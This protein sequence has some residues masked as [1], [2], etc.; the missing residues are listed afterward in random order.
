MSTTQFC[1]PFLAAMLI[2]V[3]GQFAIAQ[4]EKTSEK[5]VTETPATETPVTE[6]QQ[7]DKQQTEQA[8]ETVVR[9][10]PHLNA[11]TARD[12]RTALPAMIPVDA[13]KTASW[14]FAEQGESANASATLMVRH[15]P[16]V[17]TQVKELLAIFQELELVSTG[18]FSLDVARVDQAKKASEEVLEWPAGEGEVWRFYVVPTP[19][20]KSIHIALK[21][22]IDGEWGKQSIWTVQ[23]P[24]TLEIHSDTVVVIRQTEEMHEKLGAFFKQLNEARN[25][26]PQVVSGGGFF[27]VPEDDQP[28]EHASAKEGE[29]PQSEQAE[30]MVV[31]FYPGLPKQTAD[32]I[33]K[34]IDSLVRADWLSN[35][36]ESVVVL[37]GSFVT[38]ATLV[39]RHQPAIQKHV[40]HLIDQTRL[41]HKAAKRRAAVDETLPENIAKAELP[42]QWEDTQGRVWQ[43]FWVP[44]GSADQL[45]YALPKLLPDHAN[46]LTVSLPMPNLE[47][48]LMVNVPNESRPAIEKFFAEWDQAQKNWVAEESGLGLKNSGTATGAVAVQESPEGHGFGDASVR[49]AAKSD[50]PAAE[51]N[52][53]T[54]YYNFHGRTAQSIQ[55]LLPQVLPEIWPAD[56]KT[57]V[58]FVPGM[59]DTGATI[60][61]L[62]VRQTPAGHEKVEAYFKTLRTASQE[63][64]KQID[65]KENYPCYSQPADDSGYVVKYHY[66]PTPMANHLAELLPK[67][68]VS[69]WQQGTVRTLSG[70]ASQNLQH[71]SYSILI[72]RQQP[73][74]HEQIDKVIRNVRFYDGQEAEVAVPVPAS[75][76]GLEATV[77]GGSF[78]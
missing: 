14:V 16:E 20:A 7:S 30:K 46:G 43:L 17:H 55:K 5:P 32:A 74:V 38:P 78:F 35:N 72:V 70:P 37:G 58:S 25:E 52:Y 73:A 39:V 77:G 51:A 9:F 3:S 33:V 8:N 67:Y 76:R 1:R 65:D 71:F 34:Q 62:M 29:K 48:V 12:L 40:S 61:I 75:L 4:P 2:L 31:R 21:Q 50:S 28:S 36:G 26:A 15:T 44:A 66:L 13:E 59:G 11:R 49:N 42:K 54:R 27:N 23:L 19:S 60:G 57:S 24:G 63:L 64:Q 47:S 10:Y 41:W 18:L 53:E 68:F 45:S 6:K 22:A 69:D 56:G